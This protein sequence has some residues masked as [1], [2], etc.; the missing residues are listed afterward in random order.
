[1]SV[2]GAL[3]GEAETERDGGERRRKS[4]P[5]RLRRYHARHGSHDQVLH[6]QNNA[7]HMH[8]QRD[9][10]SSTKRSGHDAKPLRC[11]GHDA[12]LLR[13]ATQLLWCKPKLQTSAAN[14]PSAICT[15]LQFPYHTKNQSRTLNGDA[16]WCNTA[17]GRSGAAVQRPRSSVKEA[18][19]CCWAEELSERG[20]AHDAS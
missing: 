10:D 14:R 5:N 1:M 20:L 12:K 16:T 6:N 2:L 9:D 4:H 7:C 15:S 11:K 13:H 3:G 17:N 8:L 19:C 18:P